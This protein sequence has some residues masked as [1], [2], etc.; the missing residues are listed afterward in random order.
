MSPHDSSSADSPRKQMIKTRSWE[1]KHHIPSCLSH[2]EFISNFIPVK[3]DDG[4]LWKNFKT[5]VL[6]YI[7]TLVST[8]RK[9]NK[10]ELYLHKNYIRVVQHSNLQQPIFTLYFHGHTTHGSNNSHRVHYILNQ[11]MRFSSRQSISTIENSRTSHETSILFQ[12]AIVTK[13]GKID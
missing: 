12:T 13:I 2:R 9:D 10:E 7:H 8:N 5:L 3:T 4:T 11:S 6:V 1:C